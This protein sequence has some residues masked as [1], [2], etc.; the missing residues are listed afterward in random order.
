MS[1]SQSTSRKNTAM[2]PAKDL[3]QLGQRVAATH[4]W[5]AAKA[6]KSYA[7][8]EG[9]QARVAGCATDLLKVFPKEPKALGLL[10]AAL[11]V[12]LERHLS[13]PIHLVAGTL[14]VDGM[15]VRGDRM[16]FDGPALFAGSTPAWDGHLW[17]MV[18]PHVVDAAIFRM[19]YSADCPPELARHIHSVFGPGKALYADQWRRSRRLGLDYEPQYVLSTE[20]LNSLMTAAYHLMA[21]D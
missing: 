19:A 5:E 20:E 9:D 21:G 15:A 18:G 3:V 8:S 17:V 12:Q 6:F 16:P 4:G 2:R 14:S 11:A 1:P 10:N 13:A 7:W